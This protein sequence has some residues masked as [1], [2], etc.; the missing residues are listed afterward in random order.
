VVAR[1]DLHGGRVAQ[2]EVLRRPGAAGRGVEGGVPARAVRRGAVELRDE[3]VGAGRAVVVDEGVPGD[4][5]GAR[6]RRVDRHAVD[7]RLPGGGEV[8]ATTRAVPLRGDALEVG[9]GDALDALG[10]GRALGARVALFALGALGELPVLEVLG[11][12][13]AVLDLRRGDR[14]RLDLAG[15]DAV[16]RQLDRGVGGAA[17]R[18]AQRDIGDGVA[19]EV[20]DGAHVESF[21]WWS[22]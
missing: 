22:G 13:R 21:R 17:E 2:L 4:E 12:Q 7:L 11:E 5:Q 1:G 14:V 8:R 15:A 20:V 18:D 6:G 19:A 10:A 3:R 16:L 9:T